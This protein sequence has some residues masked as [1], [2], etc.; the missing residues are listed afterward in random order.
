M[1]THCTGNGSCDENEVLSSGRR[2][3]EVQYTN[4]A[5]NIENP[6]LLKSVCGVP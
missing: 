6:K 1:S 3:T 4:L 2:Y 5:Y